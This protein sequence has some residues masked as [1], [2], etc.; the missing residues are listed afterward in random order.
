ML[1]V[2]FNFEGVAHKEFV[3]LDHTVNAAFYVKV[4]KRL[5][6]R[7]TRVR[8][9]IVDF[10]KAPPWKSAERHHPRC[11]GL[12]GWTPC[13]NVSPATLQPRWRSTRFLSLP[14]TQTGSERTAPRLGP[15]HSK[16]E[17]TRELKSIRASAFEGTFCVWQS[18]WQRCV[19]AERSYFENYQVD[20]PILSTN[21]K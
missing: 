7:V 14:P 12:P 17:L 11:H 18:R 4:L 2:F 10:V 15:G 5:R 9:A 8:P 1:I 21:K 20:V 13:S 16:G 6:K 3:P 19:D